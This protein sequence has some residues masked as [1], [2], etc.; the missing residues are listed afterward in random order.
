M[1]ATTED[2]RGVAAAQV[3]ELAAARFPHAAATLEIMGMAELLRSAANELETL[4]NDAAAWD[5]GSLRRRAHSVVRA[6]FSELSGRVS[7]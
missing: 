7:L 6:L 2:S 1:R 3:S 5:C 4:A